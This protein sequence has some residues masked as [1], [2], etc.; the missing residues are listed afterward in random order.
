MGVKEKIK[1][2]TQKGNGKP[3]GIFLW[4]NSLARENNLNSDCN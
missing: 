3:I 1:T 4:T 2:Y